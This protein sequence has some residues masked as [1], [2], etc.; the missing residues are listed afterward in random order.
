MANP[1]CWNNFLVL[2]IFI[3]YV[4]VVDVVVGLCA[5]FYD[6]LLMHACLVFWWIVLNECAVH[7]G[8]WVSFRAVLFW[9]SRRCRGD[10]RLPQHLAE[11]SLYWF[12][13]TKACSTRDRKVHGANIRPTW[14]LSAPDGP[15][16]GPMNLAIRVGIKNG[17]MSS[18]S[19]AGLCHHTHVGLMHT[20]LWPAMLRSQS[21]KWDPAWT[22]GP[23]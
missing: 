8:S 18:L 3:F 5:I 14:V 17:S 20:N 1:C 15:H 2:F 4:V 13:A 7:A 23:D 22:F 10:F 16:V 21:V 11:L 12:C 6:L 9:G 19:A